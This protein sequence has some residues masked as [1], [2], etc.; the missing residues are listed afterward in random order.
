MFYHLTEEDIKV[1][2][3]LFAII[4]VVTTSVARKEDHS[5]LSHALFGLSTEKDTVI[6]VLKGQCHEIFCFCFFNFFNFSFSKVKQF[7]KLTWPG[8]GYLKK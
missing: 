3:L 4:K 2:K 1:N 7:L 8:R 5:F 6:C